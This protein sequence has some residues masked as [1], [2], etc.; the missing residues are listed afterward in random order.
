MEDQTKKAEIGKLALRYG[1]LVGAISIVLSI[2]FRIVDPLMQFTNIWIQL[3]SGVI[4]IALIVIFGI[5]IRK[6]IGGYWTFGEA[7]KG[8]MTMSFFI[9][10]LTIL[11]SFILFKFIDPNMPTK[12]NDA[13]ETVMSN[14]LAKMGMDQDKIDEVAK[15]FENGEFKAKMEPTLKNEAL[16]FGFGLVFYA[17]INLIV[18]AFIKKYKALNVLEDAV[19]PTV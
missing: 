17:V 14:R 7:F 11:Y 8:L 1:L 6:K 15:T 18:A 13:S 4:G 19:D 9:L 10:L 12:I 16:A 5:E 3:L 2:V